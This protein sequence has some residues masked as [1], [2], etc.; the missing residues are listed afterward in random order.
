MK[1][2]RNPFKMQT[3]EQIGSDSVFLRLFAPDTLSLLPKEDLWNRILIIRSSPGG[4]KTS[5]LRLFTPGALSTLYD[6]KNGNPDFVELYQKMESINAIDKDGPRV[7]GIMLSCSKGYDLLDDLD[8]DVFNRKRLFYSLLDSRIMLAAL[9]G[10]LSLKKLEYPEDIN[11]ISLDIPHNFDLPDGLPY[12]PNGKDIYKWA[13]NIEKNVC[14]AID[15]F[16]QSEP[17]PLGDKEGLISPFILNPNYVFY[18]N[19]PIMP[20]VL[21]M[22]DDCHKLTSTQRTALLSIIDQRPPIGIWISE[23]LEALNEKELLSPGALPERDLIHVDIEDSWDSSRPRFEKIVL[24]IADKRAQFAGKGDIQSFKALLNE[25][26]EGTY[27]VNAIKAAETISKR[28]EEK[29]RDSRKRRE[30]FSTIKIS[31]APP[32]TKAILYKS[33]EILI[34]RNGQKDLS[35]F[36]PDLDL[37]FD[38]NDRAEWDHPRIKSAAELMLSYEFKFPYYFGSARLASISSSNIEQFLWLAGNLF[39]EIISAYL[40]HHG[41]KLSTKRQEEIIKE[42][43]KNWWIQIPQRVKNG[44]EVMRFI[45]SI[46]R[47]AFSET[48]RPNAPYAPGVTGIAISMED[49]A[50]LVRSKDEY[51]RLRLIISDCLAHKLLEADPNKRCKGKSWYVLYLN[52]AL[53]AHFGLPLQYGGWRDKKLKVLSGWLEK[54][55]KKGDD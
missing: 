5:L 51:S 33:F 13:S 47:F 41:F 19:K 30:W 27:Q 36:L 6:Y 21:V 12:K 8:L 9:R 1:E 53:C 3:S 45:E 14:K 46:G 10:I 22:L 39:E 37:D 32:M 40:T 23:R 20:H 28:I 55:Y 24:S 17:Q 11:R 34:E 43:L 31:N 35:D 4:G 26:L 38:A 25:E 42:S 50:L 18:D 29:I 15:S 44:R 7:L 16:D 52:R 54:G 49:R 2:P 48:M